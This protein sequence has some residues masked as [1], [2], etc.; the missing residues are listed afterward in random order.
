[1]DKDSDWVATGGAAMA[2]AG[3][4]ERK[5][6]AAA[7]AATAAGLRTVDT[8]VWMGLGFLEAQI[9]E[10]R[11][12]ALRDILGKEGFS[13]A[14][15][16]GFREERAEKGKLGFGGDFKIVGSMLVAEREMQERD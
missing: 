3:W 12:K 13:E 14:R 4:R 15:N 7:T 1:M 2:A 5:T 8:T 6:A 9:C 11:V 16:W 10:V